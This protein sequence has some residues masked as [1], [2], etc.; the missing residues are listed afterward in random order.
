MNTGYSISDYCVSLGRILNLPRVKA[1]WQC[2]ITNK[3]LFDLFFAIP[4]FLFLSPFFL[5]VAMGIKIDSPGRVFFRQ[6]RIG[7]LGQPFHLIKF[8]TMREDAEAFGPQITI[9]RDSR[10]TRLG[11]LLRKA[12]IDELPQLYNVLKGEMSLVGPRPEVP[13]YVALYSDEQRQVLNLF[14]GITDPASIIYR[15]ESEILGN[16]NDPE[17]TYIN[18]IMPEKIRINLTYGK[19]QGPFADLKTILD[20]F[21]ALSSVR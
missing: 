13:R 4:G 9:G 16:S 7:R 14:P 18:L 10:I 3:R 19:R 1:S 5:V 21:A 15:D 6:M 11:C 12:K 20:T 2:M 17:G 8:R